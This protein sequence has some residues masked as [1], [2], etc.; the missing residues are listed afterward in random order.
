LTTNEETGFAI[1]EELP[2]KPNSVPLRD[3]EVSSDVIIGLSVDY[4]S[5]NGGSE[6]I[7]YQF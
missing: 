5:D 2:A 4:E 6:I 3:Q 7:S 1:I